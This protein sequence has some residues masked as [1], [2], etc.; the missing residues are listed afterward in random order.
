MI[1]NSFKEDLELIL[2]KV[3]SR[4]PFSFSK[5][6]DGEYKILIN[7][8]IT[9]CDGWTFEPIKDMVEH[10]MLLESFLYSHENYYVGINCSCCQPNSHVEWMRSVVRSE[11]VTWANLFVN[12]NYNFFVDNFFPEFN[13]WEN[14]VI[15]VGHKN[16]LSKQLPFKTNHYIPI[17]IG[18]WKEPH[19]SQIINS[20]SRMSINKSGQLFL[21]SAGPLGNILAHQ[22]HKKNPNNTYMDIGSTINPWIVGNNRGYLRGNSK[23]VCIW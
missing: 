7:Q 21:F 3:K 8:A 1:T 6:A 15:F 5:Y 23:K 20:L 2:K 9:N 13:K 4:K 17:D 18:Y 10:K 12:S 11:N 19:V 16:G 14:D 22:L